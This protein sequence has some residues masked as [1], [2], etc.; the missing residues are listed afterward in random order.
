MRIPSLLPAG[1]PARF[2]P[3]VAAAVL[4]SGCAAQAQA[5]TRAAVTLA[6]PVQSNAD[7]ARAT[8]SALRGEEIR[9]LVWNVHKGSDDEWIG[10][11]RTLAADRDLVLL[12]EAQLHDEFQHGLVGLPRW[13]MVQAWQW[14]NVPTGVLTGSDVA[15]V[16]LTA[17]EHREPMLRTDKSALITEYRIAGSDRTLLV[18]NVHAINFTVDTRA[19]QA[20]LIA[21]ADELDEHDGPVILSG[22]LNTWREERKAIVREVADA[23]GLAEVA[24]DGPRRQFGRFPLDHVYY[25]DLEVLSASVPAVGSSDHN[26]LAVSFRVP[27]YAASGE[28]PL[29][30]A[31]WQAPD[32]AQEAA[33]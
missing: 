3:L 13:D 1:Q 14:R 4:A 33:R 2:L 20:Q 30:T 18:A 6:P 9:V 31:L 28:E 5:P 29:Q 23:L 24:F 26:P 27:G 10:D 21:I 12:Q 22:D 25:R 11:F 15:P 8:D 7:A 17:L 32:A 16:R 19:F